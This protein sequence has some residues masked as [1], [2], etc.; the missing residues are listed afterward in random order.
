NTPDVVPILE[1]QRIFLA[2]N[3][4][5]GYRAHPLDTVE[6]EQFFSVRDFAVFDVIPTDQYPAPLTVD[7]LV[8]V[9][10]NNNPLLSFDDPGWRFSMIN[11]TGEKVLSRSVT[12]NNSV[13]FTSFTPAGT[14]NICVPAGGINRLY[15]VNV[16]NGS[17][18]T[19]FDNP[20][21]DDPLTV[22]DRSRILTQAGIAPTPIFLF[23]GSG[24]PQTCVGLE[25]FD[26]DDDDDGDGGG[27]DELPYV[28]SFWFQD[29]TP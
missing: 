22:D 9:T 28:R 11:G 19:N 7:D 20:Q 2:I 12:L 1:F 25:C 21:V 24:G 18:Q 27:D 23:T 8:D 6:D 26:P 16:L 3:I 10:N 14:G 15:E 5:S 17:A 4:G 29:E 13:F